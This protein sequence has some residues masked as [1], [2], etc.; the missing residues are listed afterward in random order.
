MKL[1]IYWQGETLSASQQGLYSTDS[2]TWAVVWK[3][4]TWN[5]NNC[6]W[7]DGN[8]LR[9]PSP[10]T[11]V[12]KRDATCKVQVIWPGIGDCKDYGRLEC[13]VVQYQIFGSACC[14]HLHGSIHIFLYMHFTY[15]ET[16]VLEFGTPPG[17]T[18][19]HHTGMNFFRETE[20]TVVF[21]GESRR[22][23]TTDSGHLE[24]YM[25]REVPT[26]SLA[27]Y[28]YG[29]KWL[30]QENDWYVLLNTGESI[31]KC[32]PVGRANDQSVGKVLSKLC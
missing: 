2:V 19:W 26:D 32:E 18:V 14:Q 16:V 6:K 3:R 5:Q 25:K 11:D 27:V 17:H 10:A 22:L 30:R 24:L 31:F 20:R 29:P 4:M 21:D 8:E 9:S 28:F 15:T 12:D 13:G 7:Q 23:D 1:G